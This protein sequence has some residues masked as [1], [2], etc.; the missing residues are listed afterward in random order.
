MQDERTT[1][2]CRKC[3]T[4]KPLDDF[5]VARGPRTN[6]DGHQSYCKICTVANSEA[7]RKANMD[8]ARTGARKYRAA[9]AERYRQHEENRYAR[10][11]AVKL[12]KEARGKPCVDCGI[13][14]PWQVMEL[15]HVRGEK[16]FTISGPRLRNRPPD[17]VAAEIAKCEVRCPNCHRMRHYR[18]REERKHARRTALAAEPPDLTLFEES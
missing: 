12:A 13:E 18:E 16:S 17:A 4:E 11:P 9:H 3:D 1:K 8:R 14:L 5:Y 10:S 6:R 7:W 2:W 15:D